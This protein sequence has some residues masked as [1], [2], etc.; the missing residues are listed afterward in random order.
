M[1]SASDVLYKSKRKLVRTYRIDLDNWPG[2]IASSLLSAKYI[3][4]HNLVALG[5]LRLAA[6]IA[7]KLFLEE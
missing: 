7:N 1:I 6:N 5:M 3:R 2:R 4:K